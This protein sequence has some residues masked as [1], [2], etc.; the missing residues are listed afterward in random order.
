[1]KGHELRRPWSN[2]LLG[3]RRNQPEI[4]KISGRLDGKTFAQRRGNDVRKKGRKRFKQKCRCGQR[5]EGRTF[6][7]LAPDA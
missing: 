1:M 4:D 2:V 6:D 3:R 7:R 5:V